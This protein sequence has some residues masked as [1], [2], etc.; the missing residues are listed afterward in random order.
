[1]PAT[2]ATEM[3]STEIY[4]TPPPYLRT[5]KHHSR[6]RD[7]IRGINFLSYKY[8]WEMLEDQFEGDYPKYCSFVN[9]VYNEPD[10]PG[11]L[12]NEAFCAKA[13]KW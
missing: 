5:T 8:E 10:H 7:S 12:F 9:Y 1:M 13:P 2:E 4:H 6:F 3:P 11:G